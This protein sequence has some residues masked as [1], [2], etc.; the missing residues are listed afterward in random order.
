ML[1][2]KMLRE[3]KMN[4][5]QFFSIFLLAALAM[6]LF[7]TFEGHVLSQRTAREKFHAACNLSD[8][9][10][11]GEGFSEENL[12]A[13]RNLDF[14]E[15]AQLR[16]SAVG[17]APECDGVQVDFYLERE[18]LVNQPYHISG[19]PF[20]PEDTEGIWLSAAFA[21]LR[22]IQVGDDF[23]IEYNGITF[24]KEVKGLMESAEYEYRQA[25]GDADMYLENIAIAYLS[26]DGFPI[27]EYV[28][29]FIEQEKITAENVTENTSLL[30]EKKAQLEAAGMSV[31]DITKDMLLEIVGK[32][33]DEKLAKMMPYTQMI[34]K[35]K[36]GMALPH[37]KEISDSIHQEYAAMIDRSSVPGLARLDSELEQHQ[38]FSYVFVVIFVGIAILVIATSMGRMVEKQRTQIGTMNALG[39]KKGKILFHYV[40]FSLFISALGVCVGIV[41]GTEALCPVMVDM[42]AKWYIVPGL[43]SV[44]QPVYIAVALAIVLVCVSASYISCRKVLKIRPAEALRPAPPKQGK[45]C[46]FERL[47]FWGKLGFGSQYNL[48]DISRAKLR[49][50]MCVIGTAVGMLLMIYGVGCNVLVDTLMEINFERIS[51]AD[52]QI[53]LSPD[54]KLSEVDALSEELDGEL[55]MMEQIEVSKA[56]NAVSGE[57][58]KENLTVLEG[59]KLYNILDLENQVTNLS[60]GSIGVSRKLA[61]DLDISVGDT[62]YWHIYAKNEWY[63]AKVGLIYRNSENQGIAYLREDFEWTGAEYTPSL[64]MTDKNPA[65]KE[66]LDFVTAV[67]SKKEMEDAYLSAMEVMSLMV[68]MMV[69]FSAIM[70]VVVLYNSGT[71]SFYERVKEFATL[72]V[73]GFQSSQIR[74]LLSIQNLWLSVIGILIGSPLG[75]MSLNA[76]LNSNGENFDYSLTL[77]GV[78]YL[79][80][81][82]FVLAVSMLVSFLFSKRIRTLDMVEILKGVE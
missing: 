13:V 7:C 15:E 32:I 46:V 36:D 51:A 74:R 1:F 68:A 39:M 52:Y 44:F 35:T 55:V 9:W 30:D 75:N 76:M 31:S 81:G 56:K 63:E 24:T 80:S 12:E 26:Y 79:L 50:L 71:L 54:A 77:P 2:R 6:T 69:A 19:E 22:D 60:A 43:H 33:S 62:V 57:K 65:G 4:F 10:I 3:L 21:E 61:E 37:E 14:V 41:V 64:L 38:T 48:R 67:N 11:Y 73:L 27:R 28:K 59:K 53:K 40:S 58:K 29:H 16:M 8:I 23:T 5:G 25:D 42:F 34:V 82:I 47:P 45:S 17:T 49:A 20:D 72:K 66:K 18:N 70:I 78:D